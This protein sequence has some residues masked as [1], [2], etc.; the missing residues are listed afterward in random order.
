MRSSCVSLSLR[1]FSRDQ[2]LNYCWIRFA[3]LQSYISSS[4]RVVLRIESIFGL[5]LKDTT[6]DNIGKATE[7]QKK[8]YRLPAKE[9][10]RRR[11]T[12]G[13][14][15]S[16][17]FLGYK[18]RNGALW[19]ICLLFFLRANKSESLALMRQG[20]FLYV[21]YAMRWCVLRALCVYA[22]AVNFLWPTLFGC[23]C[24]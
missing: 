16:W 12:F 13:D 3:S 9:T 22:V 10:R 21:F 6:R 24:L 17:C 4:T 5:P 18:P 2:S 8:T 15:A 1:A 11:Q 19:L 23:E 14:V 20:C 7:E